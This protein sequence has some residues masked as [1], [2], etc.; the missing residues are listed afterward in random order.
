MIALV[1]WA[2]PAA[3]VKGSLVGAYRA[4]SPSSSYSRVK[5]WEINGVVGVKSSLLQAN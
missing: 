2:C 5:I 3:E 4:K 1:W